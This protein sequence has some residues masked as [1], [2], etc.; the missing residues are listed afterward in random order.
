MKARLIPQLKQWA[1]RIDARTLRERLL[2]FAMAALVLVTLVTTLALDPAQAKR[3]LLQQQLTEQQARIAASQA[4][5]QALVAAR[6]VDPDLANRAR[7]AALKDRIAASDAK[8]ASFQQGLVGS[9]R[10]AAVLQDLLSRNRALKLVSLRTLPVSTLMDEAVKVDAKMAD[11]KGA[12]YRHGVEVT[13]EGG[14]A[15]LLA[16][17]AELEAMPWQVFWGGASLSVQTYPVSRL[18]LTLYTMSL[19]KTWLRV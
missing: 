18:T 14:Y 4:Q 15:D 19:D 1:E 7:L 12:I 5:I 3:K 8:L 10:M 16:Y 11:A 9:E 2:I 17:A 13:V 6:S